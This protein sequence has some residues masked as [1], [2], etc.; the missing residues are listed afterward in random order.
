MRTKGEAGDSWLYAADIF[1]IIFG[2][3][4]YRTLK[5]QKQFLMSY[6]VTISDNEITREQMKTPPLTISFMEIKEIV[7]F[8]K[9]SFVVKGASRTDII[10]IPT[11]IE[12]REE[13]EEYLQ[14]LAPIKVHT[15]DPWHVK[16]RWVLSILVL[17]MML[18]FY[19]L[20]NKIIVGIC[21]VA[22][23]GLVIW[24][25]YFVLTSKNIPVSGK[26]RVWIYFL[27][28]ASII[29]ATY[30]KLAGHPFL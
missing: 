12:D 2:F 20:D 3:G 11:W 30:T 26:R 27:I 25:I 17:G 13:L 6:S 19:L 5:R 29:Y 10:H 14:A 28:L 15:K 22:L 4:T 18:A 7:K 16:Y 9:G 23:V 1:P 24:A 21:G 8:E